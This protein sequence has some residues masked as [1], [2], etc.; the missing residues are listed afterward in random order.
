MEPLGIEPSYHALQARA[1]TTLAQVPFDRQRVKRRFYSASLPLKFSGGRGWI[2]TNNLLI[3]GQLL[4]NPLR[5]FCLVAAEGLEPPRSY[6]QQILSLRCLPFH[7]AAIE[8]TK[9]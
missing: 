1:M 4:C 9:S 3:F 5:A 7:H 6:E 2:R 8:T